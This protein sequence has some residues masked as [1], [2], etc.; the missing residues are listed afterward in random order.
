MMAIC[1]QKN[2]LSKL[3]TL[4]PSLRTKKGEYH[5]LMNVCYF[6]FCDILL[7]ERLLFIQLVGI[8]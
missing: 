7:L 5:I 4:L 1:I 8:P 3:N 6:I 2:L